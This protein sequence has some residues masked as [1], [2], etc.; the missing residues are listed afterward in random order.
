MLNYGM[1]NYQPLYIQLYRPLIPILKDL[2][3]LKVKDDRPFGEKIWKGMKGREEYIIQK[4]KEIFTKQLKEFITPI[5]LQHTVEHPNAYV[6]PKH[7]FFKIR[8]PSENNKK[9]GAGLLT[10]LVGD[11]IKSG[12]ILYFPVQNFKLLNTKK[13]TEKT[14][15]HIIAIT[16]CHEIMHWDQL[17]KISHECAPRKKNIQQ[18]VSIIHKSY[19]GKISEENKKDYLANPQEISAYAMNTAQNLLFNLYGRSPTPL[20]DAPHTFT[21]EEAVKQN[22]KYIFGLNDYYEMK[23]KHGKDFEKP[24]RRYMKNLSK[25]LAIFGND[26]GKTPYASLKEVKMHNRINERA[27][28]KIA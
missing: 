1:D 11:L 9:A 6:K 28:I 4:K 20:I 3:N 24:Y 19:I 18:Y 7:V 16:I 22:H 10:F 17:A 5:F 14:L 21:L 2:K 27:K 25:Q 15:A 26:Y 13:I 8:P 12:I 23:K